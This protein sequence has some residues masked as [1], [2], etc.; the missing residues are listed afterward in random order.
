M[1]QPTDGLSTV[2]LIYGHRCAGVGR[3]TD[4]VTNELAI[5]RSTYTHKA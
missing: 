4:L 5:G 3:L 1:D 2:L